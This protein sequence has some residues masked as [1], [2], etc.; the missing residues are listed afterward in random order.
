MK[1]L[2]IGGTGLTGPHIVRRLVELGHRVTLFHR[3]KTTAELRAPVTELVGDRAR[4]PDFAEELRRM[5]PDIVLDM[6]AFTGEHASALM[7]TFRGAAGRVVVISSIDVYRAYGRLH[8][9]EPGPPDPVPLV[10]D[11]PLRA[12]SEPHPDYDKPA[13]ERAVT[14][15]PELPATVLRYPAVYGPGDRQHRLFHYLRRMD[16]GR[17]AILLEEAIA[18]WRWSRG[19][20]E[21]V[22]AA[23]ALAVVDERAAGRTYNVAEPGDFP[24]AEW[25]ERIGR[26]A[27]WSGRV[28]AAPDGTL[29]DHL[30]WW[31][32]GD[33]R[34]HL[35]V[36][37][38][39]IR[40]ELGYEEVVP[41]DE[42]LRRTVAWERANP[43]ENVG[44]EAFDY[45]A[46]DAVMATL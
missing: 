29:P 9:T 16:D 44:S 3:G 36:D 37:A 18:G 1:V 35:V 12:T 25:V 45:T 6:C 4:L 20:A 26:A 24:E 31:R 38:T 7:R 21:N 28:V 40:R 14:G 10:E 42:A 11:A 33:H 30:A 13:V 43:P 5:A 41:L 27:G 32:K 46:E 17:S 39:R 22:A 15:D 8:R 2:I 23:A 19:Y 34:Q